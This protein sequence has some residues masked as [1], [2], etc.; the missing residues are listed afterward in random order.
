MLKIDR[1]AERQVAWLRLLA[2]LAVL[3]LAAWIASTR[4]GFWGWA[5]AV[6]GAGAS[7]GWVAAFVRARRRL[8]EEHRDLLEI[9]PAGLRWIEGRTEARVAWSEVRS[10]E[11]DEDALVVRVEREDAAPLGIEPRY[12]GVGL[13]ELE[14]LLRR[15]WRRGTP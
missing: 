7:A 11:T 6:A 9:D 12:E 8:R 2:G 10:I 3:G 1:R 4:P 15:A 13:H 14:D 5:M